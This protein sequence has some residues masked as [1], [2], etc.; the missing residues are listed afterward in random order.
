MTPFRIEPVAN[1]LDAMQVYGIT[2]E[3]LESNEV[4][5]QLNDLWIEH[6]IL[7]FRDT[8]NTDAMHIALSKVFGSF[9]KHP[10][11]QGNTDPNKLEITNVQYEP[12][13]ENG[14]VYRV[15][16]IE[17]GGW[18]PLHSDLIYVDKINR[19]GVLRPR[20]VPPQMGGT[21][22]LDKIT[23]YETL[24]DQ[25]KSRIAGLEV[26][27]RFYMDISTM[28]FAT[29][30]IELVRMGQKFRSIQE[31]ER[32]YPRSIHPLVTTQ[33]ET[34]RH[35]LN[36]SPWFA[37]EILG[38]E[39]S[40]SDALLRELSAHLLDHPAKFVHRWEKGDMVLWDNWRVLHGAEGLPPESGKRWLQRTTL[41][42]DY[43]FGRLEN[44]KS[45]DLELV[46]V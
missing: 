42:G 28:A 37:E 3:D 1:G 45:S 40:Q 36:L 34:G 35:I 4:R 41:A 20:I 7:I 29:E 22:F 15:G 14:N 11:A 6:G 12:G 44:A 16:G 27:Y 30:T 31:R 26:A 19:G 13:G 21:I 38:V 33:R 5:K 24:S 23:A 43:G 32:S 25:M 39:R 10:I 9:Q 2:M 17:L 46:D 18:L 8:D